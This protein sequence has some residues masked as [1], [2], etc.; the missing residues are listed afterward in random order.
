[1]ENIVLGLRLTEYH[2][3][4][5][6][7]S[8]KVLETLPY[9]LDSDDFV[10]DSEIIVQARIANLAFA[11]TPIETK[12]FPEAS[13]IGFQRSVKYGFSI[14]G[15]LRKYILFRLGL[16]SSPQ[17]II[18]PKDVAGSI[19]QSNPDGTPAFGEVVYA[20]YK[21]KTEAENTHH[22]GD[23]ITHEG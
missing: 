9:E 11:Q 18:R 15:V 17:F 3:G 13:M 2:T 20:S 10:F 8:R 23:E 16:Y 7:Y 19:A 5:R 21:N 1:M 22:Q 6:A 4:F 14:L 12:Y